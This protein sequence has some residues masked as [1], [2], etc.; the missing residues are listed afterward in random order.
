MSPLRYPKPAAFPDLEPKHW[1]LEASAGTGK[2]F[3]LE[4]LVVDLVL[5]AGL[6]LEQIVIVTFTEAAALELRR[7]IR[8]KLQE[9][10]DLQ[11][12]RFE[13][14]RAHWEL[15]DAARARLDAA[16]Q[17][18]DRTVIST[19]HAFCQK[20]LQDAAFETGRLF[21]QTRMAEGELFAEVFKNHLRTDFCATEADQ[22]FLMEALEQTGS[23]EDLE[24]LLRDAWTTRAALCP[25]ENQL[26]Q[27]RAAVGVFP[28]A[29]LRDTEALRAA[30]GKSAKTALE[31]LAL[32]DRLLGSLQAG[33]TLAAWEALAGSDLFE[34]PSDKKKWLQAVWDDA[35]PA[36]PATR[37]R[38][39][40]QALKAVL[41]TLEAVIVHRLLPPLKEAMKTRKASEGLFD[42]ND[43]IDQ[44]A[45]GV[46]HPDLAARL[47]ARYR[48]AL[49]DEFQDTD[50]RQWEIFR[51]LFHGPDHRLVLVGDP[52][53]AIYDFR[54][55][56]LP[57]YFEARKTLLEAGGARL[58]LRQNFRSSEPLIEAVN[59]VLAPEGGF[60]SAPNAYPEPVTAG[61]KP[62]LAGSEGDLPPLRLLE[63]PV[64]G[65][66]GRLRAQIA[67][68]IASVFRELIDRG[69]TL[70]SGTSEPPRP[71]HPGDLM[72]L[73]HTGTE[74]QLMAQALREA[75]LP[76]ACFKADGLFQ[77]REALELQDLL[78]AILRPDDPDAR[79]RALLTRFF[80]FGI[81]EAEACLDLPAG[82][83]VL[84]R[85]E[86]WRELAHQRRYP[87]LFN[88]ILEESGIV[89]RLLITERGDR[90]LTNLH[91]LVEQLL[92]EATASHLDPEDLLLRLGR[93]IREEDLPTLDAEPGIQRAEGQAM[94]VRLLTIH[95]AKG[96]EAPV[97]ALFGGY[98]E[99][100][101]AKAGSVHR[102]HDAANTRCA[103]LGPRRAMPEVIQELAK[104]DAERED[105]RLLYVA[106]TRPKVHLVMPVF[107]PGPEPPSSQG[108]FDADAHP[109]G[110]H[111]RLNRRVRA[112]KEAEPDTWG[113][114]TTPLPVPVRA[115]PE[116]SLPTLPAQ[117][118]LPPA[119]P[120]PDFPALSR[121]GRPLQ[122]HS[123]T[124][125]ARAFGET[126]RSA[127]QEEEARAD[128]VQVPRP[129]RPT[130]GLPGGTATGTALHELLERIPAGRTRNLSP[131]AWR[132]D[133]LP[134]AAECLRDQGLSPAL[135]G[136]AL[137]LAWAA[138]TTELHLPEGPAMRLDDL[139]KRLPEVA[140]QMPFPDHPDGLEGSLDLLFEWEGRIYVLDWKTNTLEDGDYGAE[141]LHRTMAAHYDLQ[142]RIYTLAALAFA[143]IHDETAFQ[144][145]FGGAVYV[146]LRGLP[147]GGIWTRRPSWEEVQIWRRE[148]GA[149]HLE[150]LALSRMERGTHG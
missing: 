119:P 135:A 9:L 128:E 92:T 106:I 49:I 120:A 144:A 39:A 6:P 117:L 50:G 79:G 150:E 68:G 90:S 133:L 46:T 15:D 64:A 107:T 132:E 12:D 44:V 145:R 20:V 34:A 97:V 2:T 53:Q 8:Q 99:N 140:F 17:A 63:V 143:G 84:A 72:V 37:I 42:F 88:A 22:V 76:S 108:S 105:E 98:S 129:Q 75:G 4:H 23:P 82:H 52:K 59:T 124:S 45:E 130:G 58:A 60:F 47:Q 28:M 16:L 137:R 54:G 86:R 27:A 21:R 94:A 127:S 134:L 55:G 71:L 113:A 146:F 85:L 138:L 25:D 126:R 19:I 83:P 1:V 109:K 73:T 48:A 78:G 100:Q 114:W 104:A 5:T 33:E 147:A 80:G 62:R 10:R 41:P 35:L 40:L 142:V 102:F 43:M 111:G 11:E 115:L 69:T 14:G 3:T 122:L 51:R 136:E 26:A 116:G 32:L 123:F 29:D 61:R 110:R 77:T 101:L 121:R 74:S 18:F 93:W 149:M 13:P 148:L 139:E 66:V 118:Q 131:E 57:T 30:Y 24:K 7:R 125:L 89:P 96:L 31:R 141:S 70:H 81:A 87:R 67:A 103:F 95:K 112:L 56:D 38:D 36:G 91:H 65:P